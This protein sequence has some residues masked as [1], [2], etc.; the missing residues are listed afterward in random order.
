MRRCCGGAS[1]RVHRVLHRGVHSKGAIRGVRRRVIKSVGVAPTR[2]HHCFGSLPRSDVPFVPARMRIR[3]VAVRPGVPRRRVR[4][5]GGAL[6][7]C[8]RH[9]ASNRVT[10]SALTHLCSRSRNSHHHNNR[11]NFVN[12]TRLMPR[13]TGITFGLRSPGGMSGVIRSRFNFRV[14]RLVRGHNSHVGAHRVLLGPGISRGSLRTTLLHLSSVT[15]S[16]HG[17][18]FAFSSTTACVSR[19]GS[20]HGGRNLVTG[21]RANATHFRV[22]RLTRISRRTTGVIR[23]VG[24]KRVSGPFAVVGTGKGRVYTVIGLGAHLGKRGTAVARSCR[25]LGNVIVR[26]HDRRGLSG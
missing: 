25:Q 14:V 8:A 2:I 16:V 17:R 5:I 26:G 7:S 18:G 24:I 9:I 23:N 20:A 22:R 21:P 10:F 4:H 13:C 15:G 3:V 11:L 12:E 6:H 19:S 1:A